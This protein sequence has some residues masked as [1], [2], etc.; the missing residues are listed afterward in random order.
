MQRSL[1]QVLGP[2]L[3]WA[4]TAIGV[5][6][7]VQSTRAGAG[8]G[9]ALLWLVVAANLFKYPGFEAGPRYA[10]ATGRSLLEGYR[11]L[12]GWALWLFLALTLST[13]VTVIATVTVV[14]AGMA[15]SLITDAIP[16]WG[17]SALLLTLVTVLLA[18]GRFKLLDGAMKVMV[19]ALTVST[20]AALVLL[21][22]GA[23]SSRLTVWPPLPD[24]EPTTLIFLCGLA[25]WMPSALDTAVWQSLWGLEKARTEGRKWP[26]PEA[27]LDF[28][29]G[30]VGTA[31]L[32]VV[33]VFVG[34]L[35]LHGVPTETPIEEASAAG[36]AGILVDMY[37]AALGDWARPIILVAAF[38]TMLSTTLSCTDGFPRAVEGGIRR[39][40]GPEA[41]GEARTG[42]YWGALLF[43]V[44]AAE[45]V[46]VVVTTGGFGAQFLLLVQVATV[47][48]GLTG[49][50]FGV[51]NLLV[52]RGAEV[53]EQH[54]PSAAFTAFHLAGIAFMGAL[55]LVLVYA[56]VATTTGS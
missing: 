45:V 52:L 26:V 14:T 13:M 20:L 49:T 1:I 42:L 47:L 6:H 48:T 27:L 33:F 9:L 22:P 17:W 55:A 12:G 18:V 35:V 23:E 29:V 2:G 50:V 53:P 31:I 16:V 34:A 54:R 39:L 37:A 10:A 56:L 25:G 40:R 51:L 4:G 43:C 38:A 24:W 5:S 8:F 21:V 32:A 15:S 28:N 3:I 41:E 7:L 30:Y 46:I 19:I 11:R 36:F 44:L